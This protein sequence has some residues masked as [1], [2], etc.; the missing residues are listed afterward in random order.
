MEFAGSE[1]AKQGPP[2]GQQ[3]QKKSYI[4]KSLLVLS[5]MINQLNVKSSQKQ[6]VFLLLT[7]SLNFC[8]DLAFDLL[9]VSCILHS[10]LVCQFKLSQA[11]VT[12]RSIFI[13][14]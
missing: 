5:T 9:A 11:S 12:E 14:V 7:F 4:N 3:L 1:N 8:C 13:D 10:V 2:T 6:S